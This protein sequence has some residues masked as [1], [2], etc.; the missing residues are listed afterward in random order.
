[1]TVLSAMVLQSR[2]HSQIYTV[3]N[4]NGIRIEQE[5]LSA[6]VN[7]Q[8]PLYSDHLLSLL[9]LLLHPSSPPQ[10]SSLLH[11]IGHLRHLTNHASKET[12]TVFSQHN[13]SYS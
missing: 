1:M 7:E 13:L 8:A 12:N 5:S 4:S 9:H 2:L 6:L 3:S 10:P 11:K